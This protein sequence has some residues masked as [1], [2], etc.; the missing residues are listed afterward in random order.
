MVDNG[1]CGRGVLLV[2]YWQKD[3]DIPLTTAGIET[4]VYLYA[5]YVA[6]FSKNSWQLHGEVWKKI[7]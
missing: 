4:T 3:L 6:E 5:L 7:K 2:Q 1:G